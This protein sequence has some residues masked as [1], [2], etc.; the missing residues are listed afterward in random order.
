MQIFYEMI[1]W[2]SF[3]LEYELK[4][5]LLKTLKTFVFQLHQKFHETNK[6]KNHSIS[7]HDNGKVMIWKD[8]KSWHGIVK[9]KTIW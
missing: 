1:Q 4:L 6:E 7:T 2:L 5:H 9:L 8:F 3:N